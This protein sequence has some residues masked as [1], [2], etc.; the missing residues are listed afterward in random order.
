MRKGNLEIPFLHEL[1]LIPSFQMKERET[2]LLKM[3]YLKQFFKLQQEV[4]KFNDIYVI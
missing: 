4:L 2:I 1:Y 3:K